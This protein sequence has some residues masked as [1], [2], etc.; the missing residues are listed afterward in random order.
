MGLLE[1]SETFEGKIFEKF[2]FGLLIFESWY[3][4]HVFRKNSIDY[5]FISKIIF[6]TMK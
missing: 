4:K 1:T 6:S 5:V 3:P 2:E